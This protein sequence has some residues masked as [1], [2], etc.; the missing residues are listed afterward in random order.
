VPFLPVMDGYAEGVGLHGQ[1]L[2]LLA[3]GDELAYDDEGY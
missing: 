2:L 3:Y 1:L